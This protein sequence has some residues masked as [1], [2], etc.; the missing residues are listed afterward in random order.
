[1]KEDASG[2]FAVDVEL[3]N[4]VEADLDAF[5]THQLDQEASGLIG[6]A[7]RYKAEIDAH[8]AKVLFEDDIIKQTIL[9]GGQ[10][11]GHIVCFFQSGEREIGYWL[12]SEFGAKAS[13]Q[14][15]SLHS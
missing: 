5:F 7:P 14:K 1:L 3:R 8:W 9:A 10:V 13:P 2:S 6:F 15:P 12:G 11:A 4:V